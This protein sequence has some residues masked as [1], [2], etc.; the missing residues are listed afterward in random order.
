VQHYKIDSLDTHAYLNRA[1]L[2][3]C[4]NQAL[5][6]NYA[7]QLYTRTYLRHTS[8]TG[9]L[10]DMHINE[11]GS[12]TMGDRDQKIVHRWNYELEKSLLLVLPSRW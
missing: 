8:V 3:G 12:K 6:E 9:R 4:K 1:A 2:V 10:G 5:S 7:K 11:N